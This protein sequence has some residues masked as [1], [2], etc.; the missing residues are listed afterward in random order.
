MK[1]LFVT[2]GIL[3]ML[4]FYA[5]PQSAEAAGCTVSDPCVTLV[6]SDIVVTVAGVQVAK[7]PAPVKTVQVKVPVPGPVKTIIQSIPQPGTTVIIPGPT[8][9]VKVPGP[10]VTII[11]TVTGT[12]QPAQTI[13]SKPTVRVTPVPVPSPSVVVK[14]VP[15][16]TKTVTVTRTKAAGIS[17]LILILGIILGFT[18]VQLAGRFAKRKAQK[19]E[20]SHLADLRDG[21]FPKE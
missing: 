16:K 15:G 11:K 7:I 8:K 17:L 19:E 3:S 6:G 20:V 13:T 4:S 5:Y 14:T 21:L 12:P 1:R 18:A 2:L 10:T 9:T